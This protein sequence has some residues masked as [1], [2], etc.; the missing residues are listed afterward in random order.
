MLTV[1]RLSLLSRYFWKLSVS[2]RVLSS[3]LAPSPHL[4][5]LFPSFLTSPSLPHHMV[6]RVSLERDELKTLPAFPAEEA[7]VLVMD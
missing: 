2:Y 3:H 6:D 7:N 1:I 4:L 5:L